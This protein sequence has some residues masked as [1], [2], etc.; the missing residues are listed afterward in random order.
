M[1]WSSLG[2]WGLV[3]LGIAA[4]GLPVQIALG[5]ALATGRRVPVAVALVLP[6]IVLLLGLGGVLHGYS[7]VQRALIDPADPA[8]APWY[9][10]Y[11]R[12]AA[13]SPAPL[14]GMLTLGLS[15][16]ALVGAA[17]AALRHRVRGSVG[18]L[19]AAAG[20]L[21]AGVA[22]VGLAV[23]LSR[24]GLVLPGLLVPL[25]SLLGAAS[26]SARRPSTLAIPGV[27]VAG[28]VVA[29]FGLVVTTLGGLE[30][31]VTDLLD[32]LTAASSHLDELAAHEALSHTVALGVLL[33]PILVGAAMLPGLGFVRARDAGP[34]QGLDIAA[35]GA[36][37]GTTA[38][39]MMWVLVRRNLL[40]RLAGA[41]ASWVL[42]AAPG[43]DVPHLDVLPPR[44]LVPGELQST[45]I[46]LH[47]GGGAERTAVEGGMDQ[48]GKGLS[49]GDGVI[50]PHAWQME[51]LYYLLI[52]APAGE[53]ALVGCEPLPPGLEPRLR[54]E[55]LLAVG[56]CGA[57][58]LKLRVSVGMPDP[59]E[60]IL[61]PGPHVQDGFDVIDLDELR[62]IAGRDVVLRLQMD[63]TVDDL[64][65]GLRALRGA[66]SVYLGWG[67]T[68][69]G[70]D[71]TIGVEPG[72]RVV[73][74]LPGGGL[75]PAPGEAAPAATNAPAVN[76]AAAPAVPAVPASDPA[77]VLAAP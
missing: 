52:E 18:P 50:L 48:V 43:Y 39:S 44:V 14:T 67:V 23:H 41:H 26:L 20:G 58:P 35:T 59:R 9:A 38:L 42:A 46:E 7:V 8:W 76:A 54:I 31:E 69:E 21:V 47:D 12:A 45:W 6:V 74:H 1:D 51:D 11:D 2:D 10:W 32:D 53:V 56:R 60:L 49:R 75:P 73:E 40:G 77:S 57:F 16:P 25:V 62:D 3:A 29:T 15:V 28:A 22:L 72:L 55:P 71:L 17:V 34:K 61:V 19:V 66:A 24:P 4:L 37:L 63:C 27:G 70:D 68:T 33:L 65:A 5:S 64:I 30:S 36:L 13:A